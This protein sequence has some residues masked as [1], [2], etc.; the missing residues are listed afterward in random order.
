MAP[1][2]GVRPRS[3]RAWTLRAAVKPAVPMAAASR[4]LSPS[5]F[6]THSAGT[7]AYSAKPPWWAT[8]MS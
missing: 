7:L 5:S 2:S 4:V 6:T 1:S 8:P 3:S